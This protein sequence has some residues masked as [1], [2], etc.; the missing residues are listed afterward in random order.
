MNT[1]PGQT[2]EPELLSNPF[3]NVASKGRGASVELSVGR[4]I[5]TSRSRV[6]ERCYPLLQAHLAER[7][8]VE[9]IST[10]TV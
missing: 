10:G 7:G 1:H 3:V 2:P 5:A 4:R 9:K 8:P 6:A